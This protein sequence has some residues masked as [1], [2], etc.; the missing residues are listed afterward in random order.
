MSRG[1]CYFD[2]EQYDE[3]ECALKMSL[4]I[5]IDLNLKKKI[6][7]NELALTKVYLQMGDNEQAGEHLGSAKSVAEEN[8]YTS[9]LGKVA[10]LEARLLIKKGEEPD[11]KY[12]TAISLF[13]SLGRERDAN[14]ILKELEDYANSKAKEKV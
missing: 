6:I 12:K 13:E 9:D 14:K 11:E 3:S 1:R 10:H 2:L 4:N 5:H 8:D 7:A